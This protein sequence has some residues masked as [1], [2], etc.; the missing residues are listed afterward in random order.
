[1]GYSPWDHRESDT[2]EL[3]LQ[4]VQVLS[5]VGELK[6]CKPCDVAKKTKPGAEMPCTYPGLSC[7][8]LSKYL[9]ER[10]DCRRQGRSRVLQEQ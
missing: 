10:K 7:H 2:T 1:M 9:K 3:P 4:E 5:L 8:H 6:S